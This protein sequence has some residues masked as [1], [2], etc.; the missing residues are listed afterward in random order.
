M[1]GQHFPTL[2]VYTVHEEQ[3]IKQFIKQFIN[4]QKANIDKSRKN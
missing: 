1:K 2:T 4:S 3:F